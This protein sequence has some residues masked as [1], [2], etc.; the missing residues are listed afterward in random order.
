[1]RRQRTG[2]EIID[3]RGEVIKNFP[4]GP[5]RRVISQETASKMKEILSGVVESGTG[6]KARVEGYSA[7]GKTGSAKKV[8]PGGVYSHNRFMASFIGFAPLE[9]PKLAIAVCIDEPHPVY[10]GG[11]VAAPVF[12]RVAASSLKYLNSR[13][14]EFVLEEA[15]EAR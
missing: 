15:A 14:P 1:M 8:E 4:S 12:S 5:P 11:D 2:R 7:G 3:S 6:K 9:D 10:Y 13:E